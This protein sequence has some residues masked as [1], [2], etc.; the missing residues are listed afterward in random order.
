[1]T[2]TPG[3]STCTITSYTNNFVYS[4]GSILITYQPAFPTST[5]NKLLISLNSTYTNDALSTLINPQITNYA[6]IG[7]AGKYTL[8]INYTT[9]INITLLF[10]PSTKPVASMIFLES[11]I[12]GVG[13]VDYCYVDIGNIQANVMSLNV[14]ASSLIVQQPATYSFSILP[15]SPIMSSD[16]LVIEFPSSYVLTNV[17]SAVFYLN[18]FMTKTVQLNGSSLILSFLIP[19]YILGKTIKFNISNIINPFDS[20]SV[21]VKISIVTSDGFVRDTA[22]VS[23]SI[24]SGVMAVNSFTCGT[25][26]IGYKTACKLNFTTTSLINVDSQIRLLFPTSQW[27]LSQS[28]ANTQCAVTSTSSS[29]QLKSYF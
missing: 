21:V 15:T 9:T 4:R 27:M 2:T 29:P 17:Q 11:Y 24:G 13:E 20:R 10:P 1:M 14:T 23:L 3:Q 26:Q 8:D 6:Q 5:P 19:I 7:T 18:I 22:S 16:S 28:G 25:Y 12:D